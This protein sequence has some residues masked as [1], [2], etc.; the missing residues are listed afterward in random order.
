VH[1]HRIRIP[2]SEINRLRGTDDEEEHQ[3]EEHKQEQHQPEEHQRKQAD[4]VTHDNTIPTPKP[5]PLDLSNAEFDSPTKTR[6]EVVGRSIRAPAPT[7]DPVVGELQSKVK[8]SP[9]RFRGLLAFFHEPRRLF[10]YW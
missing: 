1:D 10:P 7:I 4:L 8:Q 3:Q 5:P 9:P 2:Q 6:A